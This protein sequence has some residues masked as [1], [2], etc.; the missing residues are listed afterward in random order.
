MTP[1]GDPLH[2]FDQNRGFTGPLA[3]YVTQGFVNLESEIDAVV[4]NAHPREIRALWRKRR[5][6]GHLLRG[7]VAT[8]ES[9]SS[10]GKTAVF[11]LFYVASNDNR[12]Y[13]QLTYGTFT[14]AEREEFRKGYQ[15]E[16]EKGSDQ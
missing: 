1:P 3:H 16:T 15:G 9:M 6:V 8:V 2:I 12:H 5:P 7:F 13:I 11:E 14:K 10:G 4:H